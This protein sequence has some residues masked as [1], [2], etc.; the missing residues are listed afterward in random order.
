MVWHVHARYEVVAPVPTQKAKVTMTSEIKGRY[1]HAM[2]EAGAARNP[3]GIDER[4]MA[5]TKK[6]TNRARNSSQKSS[7]HH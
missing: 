6:T 3:T 5:V 1:G 4:A 2:L 7:Q